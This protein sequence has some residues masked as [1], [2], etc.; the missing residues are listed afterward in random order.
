MGK[1]ILRRVEV[2]GLGEW[3]VAIE[4]KNVTEHAALLGISSIHYRIVLAASRPWRNV[5]LGCA[6]RKFPEFHSQ[7][8]EPVKLPAS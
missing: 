1:L 3:D 4:E 2:L 7:V 8:P 5:D 6:K